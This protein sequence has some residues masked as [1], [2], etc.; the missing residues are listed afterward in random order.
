MA[1]ATWN[2]ALVAQ[3]DQTVIFEGNHYFPPDAVRREYFR[4]SATHS[5]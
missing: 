1:K 3:S 5:T 2:G 4:D